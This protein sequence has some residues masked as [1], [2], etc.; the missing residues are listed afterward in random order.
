MATMANAFNALYGVL[1]S[2]QK[3]IADQSVGMMRGR[4]MR[5]GPRAG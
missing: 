1:T 2:E 4:G 5:H 3:T